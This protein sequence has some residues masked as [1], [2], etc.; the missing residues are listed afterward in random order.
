MQTTVIETGIPAPPVRQYQN[1]LTPELKAMEP[2]QSVKVDKRTAA[3]LRAYGNRLGWQYSSRTERND[4]GVP[5]IRF[6]RVA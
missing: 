6:W 2:G 1:R 5:Y 4:G 3:A